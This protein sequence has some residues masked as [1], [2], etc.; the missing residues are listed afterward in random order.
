FDVFLVKSPCGIPIALGD[1]LEKGFRRRGHG[2]QSRPGAA[3]R[4]RLFDWRLGAVLSPRWP[5]SAGT[6]QQGNEESTRIAFHSSSPSR[7]GPLLR[8]KTYRRKQPWQ[9]TPELW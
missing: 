9:G 2:R 4:G 8:E 1:L 3:C 7:R 5:P 6:G